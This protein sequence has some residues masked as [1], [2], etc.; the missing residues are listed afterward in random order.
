MMRA[1]YGLFLLV[2]QAI[3]FSVFA[4][5]P[6]ATSTQPVHLEATTPVL[7]ETG[8][9]KSLF[10]DPLLQTLRN[11]PTPTV[12]GAFK[13]LQENK[14]TLSIT[15]VH[16]PGNDLYIGGEQYMW[17]DAAIEKVSAILDDVGH[18]EELF[19]GYADI[20]IVPKDGP[21]IIA[22]GATQAL[23]FWEQ[24]IPI[25]FVPNIKYEMDYLIDKSS[26]E[27]VIYRYQLKK[28]ER[29]KLSDGF[30]LLEK[31]SQI[32]RAHV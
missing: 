3:A 16:P 11:W 18:Y 4:A 29:I 25:P 24:H 23:L 21:Q 8:G 1:E 5:L 2:S 9:V 27:R 15:C 31:I 22:Q 14:Q 20:H 28:P 17:V 19:P 13:V 10:T 30:I 32:G 12:E 7:K 6:A 26:S